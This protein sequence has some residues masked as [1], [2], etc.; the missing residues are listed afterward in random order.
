[1]SQTLGN[2]L[3]CSIA[4]TF[5]LRINFGWVVGKNKRKEGK[6]GILKLI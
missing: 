3:T 6:H 4:G 5:N 2:S 1:M